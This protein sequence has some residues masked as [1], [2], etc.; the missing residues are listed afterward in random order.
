M[1]YNQQPQNQNPQWVGRVRPFVP[2][3]KAIPVYQNKMI[4][5][6][7]G[8]GKFSTFS[9]KLLGPNT[10]FPTVSVNITLGSGTG[11]S[12][13]SLSPK[14]FAAFLTAITQWTNEFMGLVPNLERQADQLLSAKQIFDKQMAAIRAAALQQGGLIA[15]DGPQ[16]PSLSYE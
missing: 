1:T 16:G 13:A 10:D 9:L 12:F 7:R 8:N 6:E 11:I 3:P 4:L 15:E 2:R 14:E 5:A